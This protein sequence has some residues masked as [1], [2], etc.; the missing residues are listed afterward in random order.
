MNTGLQHLECGPTHLNPTFGPNFVS[1]HGQI[2]LNLPY[3]GSLD[4]NQL[5]GINV[6]GQGT[7]TSEGIDK[8]CEALRVNSTLQFIRYKCF[9]PQNLAQ[10]LSAAADKSSLPLGSVDDHPL[11]IKQLKGEEAVKEIDLSNKGLGV[12]SAIIIASLLKENTATES[13]ECA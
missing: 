2:E 10:I 4:S 8:I 9:E 3:C 6:I 7:Y 11:P 12:A 1:S 5:C 13:L